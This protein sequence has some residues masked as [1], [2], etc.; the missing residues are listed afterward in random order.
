MGD[1]IDTIDKQ[2]NMESI[3]KKP[4]LNRSFS[5]N[6][7]ADIRDFQSEHMIHK[8][9]KIKK[10]KMKNNY[11]NVK[12]LDILTN[13]NTLPTDTAN[14]LPTD[15]A[16][17]IND[18]PSTATFQY[19]KNLIFNKD[20]PIV[21]GATGFKE[22]EYEGIE[23]P[24]NIKRR[25]I[26]TLQADGD[27]ISQLYDY[28][29]SYN[30]YLSE[31]L[32]GENDTYNKESEVREKDIQLVRNSIV[33]LECA[34]ISSIMV[35]NW[36]FAIYFAKDKGIHIP[37]FSADALI[38][39]GRNPETKEENAFITIFLWFFEFALWFPEKLNWLLVD[40]LPKTS[41]ILNGTCNFLFL[42]FVCLYCT[43]FFAIS[44]KTFFV[45]LLELAGIESPPNNMVLI[46]TVII[47]GLFISSLFKTP[48]ITD[49]MK[50][51]ADAMSASAA[52]GGGL[53]SKFAKGIYHFLHLIIIVILCVPA[54]AIG[55]GLYL[56]YMSFFSRLTW[57]NWSIYSVL[58]G[59]DSINQID[60]HIRSSK[61]GFEETD[62]CN[63]D[64]LFAFLYSFLSI[65]F[66]FLDYFK[67]HLL[68]IIYTIMLAIITISISINMSS[69][70]PNKLPLNFFAAAISIAAIV[71][72]ITSVIRYYELNKPANNDSL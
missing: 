62:L 52:A 41:G 18:K 55:C 49:D 7:T 66:N 38:E 64:N 30:T 44:F 42:Y 11:K 54:G 4:D 31:I 37:S 5:N 40:I 14:T 57:G 16:N 43:K 69:V 71:M 10:K 24:K 25:P 22:D 8:L 13:D 47:I 36:Y 28:I 63:S 51:M 65:I 15:T 34:F 20:K 56:I 12:E 70:A 6:N 58:F 45:D 60:K 1:N 17:T 26:V 35:Y 72:V 68:K 29:N 67:E 2:N 61:A 21:E 23:K 9:K 39:W 50:G 27:V 3:D 53:I 32:V 59:M 48:K 33:W 19:I 46:M